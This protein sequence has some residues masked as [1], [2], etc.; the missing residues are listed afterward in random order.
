LEEETGA[1]HQRL[2]EETTAK[3]QQPNT[4]KFSH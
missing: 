2:E 3:K 4:H 1:L